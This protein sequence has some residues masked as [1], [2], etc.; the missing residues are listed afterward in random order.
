[1]NYKQNEKTVGSD[2]VNKGSNEFRV[3]SCKLRVE[4]KNRSSSSLGWIF[5][6]GGVKDRTASFGDCPK[7]D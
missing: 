1:M 2:E 4:T 3:T 5:E 6:E 7:E